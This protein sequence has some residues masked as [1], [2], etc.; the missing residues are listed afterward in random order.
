MA[1]ELLPGATWT[2][3]SGVGHNPMFDDPALVART[4]LAVT[5]AAG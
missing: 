1:R 2:V 5:G 4:I 3:L